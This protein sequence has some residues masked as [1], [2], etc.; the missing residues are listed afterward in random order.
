[1]QLPCW[2]HL[3]SQAYQQRI[4]GLIDEIESEAAADRAQTGR[5]P[6]GPKVILRQKPTDQPV[7]TKK[8]PAPL[9]HAFRRKVRKALY[10]AY[11]W[12]VAVFRTAAEKLQQGDRTAEFPEGSFPPHLPF[13][14][15][16]LAGATG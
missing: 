5:E 9:F 15:A 3:S 7:K 11:G 2:T 12:F 1:M 16:G 6:L 8:S 13:V 4:R 14:R 10:E